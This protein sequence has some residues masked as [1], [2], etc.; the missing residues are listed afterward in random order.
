[1]LPSG[2]TTGDH[3]RRV[4]RRRRPC[5]LP[6]VDAGEQSGYVAECV[7]MPVETQ[8]ATLDVTVA[9]LY[10]AAELRLEAA[11]LAE[12]GLAANPTVVITMELQPCRPSLSNA[13]LVL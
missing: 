6:H 12:M 4:I 3:A 11:H 2:G 10:E 1:M 8:G 9:N 7:E 5:G 13:A